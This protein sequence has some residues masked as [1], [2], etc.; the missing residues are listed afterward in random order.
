[1]TAGPLRVLAAPETVRRVSRR[2]VLRG[3]AAAAV[4]SS[5]FLTGCG[6]SSKFNQ[7][8]APD[9]SLEDSVNLY[10]WGEYDD[11]AVLREFGE[12]FGATIRLD[13]Y[14]SNEELI[15]KLS[16]G[17]GTAGYDI[18]VPS[19]TYVK[20]MAGHGLLKK[21]DKSL[22][23]NMKY[24]DPQFLGQPFD[25]DNSHSVCKAWGTVG[26]V[27][28]TTV[29]ER[30]LVDWRDF[31]DAAGNEA[32]GKTTVLDDPHE[33]TGLWFGANGI[34]PN[35]TK[36]PDLD[37]CEDALVDTLAPNLSAFDSYPGSGA[38]QQGAHVL[39]QAYN[40]DARSGILQSGAREKWRFV[41][42]G[43]VASLWMDN[44]TIATGAPH[45][46]A[47]YAFINWVI[48]PEQSIREVAYAGYHTGTAGI[49]RLAQEQEMP[50]PEAIFFTE[51][52]IS[53]MVPGE[54]NEA[55]SRKIEILNKMKVK[56]GA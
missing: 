34:S 43:P 25:P 46:D 32:A 4:G 29:I 55:M 5:V 39:M 13:G 8:P 49:E 56:A 12:K 9:G 42:G 38:I 28:D 52:Q 31:L 53:T 17:R 51:E 27:Y 41:L 24:F 3:A 50:M 7:G 22:L 36:G 54:L 47:S 15:A 44:W 18:V 26:F 11:P 1:M 30:D 14:T 48:E 33:V 10:T 16:A 37:A 23:P 21:L 45:P 35:T 6:A 40:G 2:A 20:A 19:G